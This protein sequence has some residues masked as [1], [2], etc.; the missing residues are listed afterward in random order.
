[1]RFI[2]GLF[3]YNL[4]LLVS[5][6]RIPSQRKCESFLFSVGLHAFSLFAGSH[7]IT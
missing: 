6:E 4:N 2:S 1:V 7:N 3:S 5:V